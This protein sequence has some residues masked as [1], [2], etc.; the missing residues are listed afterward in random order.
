MFYGPN[1]VVD[2][3]NTYWGSTEASIV[4]SS[5]KMVLSGFM[6]LECDLFLNTGL[7]WVLQYDAFHTFVY[8]WLWS[9]FQ[10]QNCGTA[11]GVTLPL[12]TWRP[13]LVRL[14]FSARLVFNAIRVK[15][16]GPKMN[17]IHWVECHP[18]PSFSLERA[19]SC[20]GSCLW[21]RIWIFGQFPLPMIRGLVSSNCLGLW[22][23]EAFLNIGPCVPSWADAT[24][25]H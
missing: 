23:L 21:N 20:C 17:C 19:P 3:G 16:G 6:I 14:K 18:F 10:V 12:K 25:L 13:K 22:L 9:T 15:A 11:P 1:S 5:W 4:L 8:C 7:Y 24:C 2:K